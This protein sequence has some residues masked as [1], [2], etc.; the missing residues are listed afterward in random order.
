MCENIWIWYNSFFF[1]FSC[2][3]VF[4]FPCVEAACGCGGV[5][6]GIDNVGLYVRRGGVKM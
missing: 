6:A 3:S 2:F 5:I 4:F 1:S